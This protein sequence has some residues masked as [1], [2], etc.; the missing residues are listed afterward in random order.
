MI[1]ATQNL[2]RHLHGLLAVVRADP[3]R[4]WAVAG[5]EPRIRQLHD[6]LTPAPAIE[7]RDVMLVR[8]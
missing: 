4:S 5:Y 8:D 2:L 6:E 1:G 3:R 7:E